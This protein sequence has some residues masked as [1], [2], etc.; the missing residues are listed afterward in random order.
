MNF[1]GWESRAGN[2]R[3]N[4]RMPEDWELRKFFQDNNNW[5]SCGE[6]LKANIT[7]HFTGTTDEIIQWAAHKWG[8]DVDIVRAVA[9]KESYWNQSQVGDFDSASGE[10]MSY[11]LTQVR[12]NQEGET[13]PNWNGTF[14]LSKD[15]TAFNLDYWGFTV[16]QYF[17]GCSTWLNDVGGNPYYAGDIWGSVGAWFAGRWWN[18]GAQSYIAAVQE[19][20][21]RKVWA[22]TGF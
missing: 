6:A 15:S 13:A 1:D 9:V 8:I 3:E 16:R 2:W 11:G 14:P 7:G 17:E 21:A 18:D 19:N 4:A 22:Q 10:Y 20:L 5:S 12:R